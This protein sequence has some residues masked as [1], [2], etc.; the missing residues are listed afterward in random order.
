MTLVERE[1][2]LHDLRRDD[3][4]ICCI[5]GLRQNWHNGSGYSYLSLPRADNGLTL[6]LCRSAEYT[7]TDGSRVGAERGDIVL[8]PAGSRY[9]VEFSLDEN[10]TLPASLLINFSV[11]GIDG[12]L[13][14]VGAAPCVVASDRSGELRLRFLSVIDEFNVGRQLI[15]KAKLLGLIERLC[16]GQSVC[17]G[18]ISAITG[19]IDGRAGNVGSVGE[20]AQKFSLGESTLRRRFSDTLGV[21]PGEYIAAQKTERIKELLSIGEITLSDICE[22]LGFCDTAHLCKFFRRQ[23]GMTMREWQK[24]IRRSE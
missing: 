11:R 6:I 10:D 13:L 16:E 22:Q 20:L 12:G 5:V 15:C 21:S 19:Y 7:F 24:S 9:R 23:T 1:I 3:Y 14:S 2:T 4:N 8:T 18:S 17:D